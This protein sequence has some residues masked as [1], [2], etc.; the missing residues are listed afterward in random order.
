M[1]VTIVMTRAALFCNERHN[2]VD[3]KRDF[4]RAVVCKF[5]SCKYIFAVDWQQGRAYP[6]LLVHERD[7]DAWYQDCVYIAYHMA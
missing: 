6:S 4:G 1:T 7:F 3:E 2:A 5:R